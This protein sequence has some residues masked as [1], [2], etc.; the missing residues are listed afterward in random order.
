MIH[1]E[2]SCTYKNILERFQKKVVL[3]EQGSCTQ[4]Y[5]G[6]VSEKVV[7]KEQWYIVRGAHA[8]RNILER[9][10]IKKWSSELW[11]TVTGSC[12][13]TLNGKVS[14]NKWS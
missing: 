12:T 9:F 11:Y 8:H 3:K 6:K 1:S 2:G 10:Q 5:T 7:L 13:Q 14:E 4:K